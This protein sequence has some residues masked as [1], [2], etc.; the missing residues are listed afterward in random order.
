MFDVLGRVV[1]GG[2]HS[3]EGLALL[4]LHP[5]ADRADGDGGANMTTRDRLLD[6]ADRLRRLPPPDRRDPERFHLERS[7]LAAELRALAAET[8]PGRAA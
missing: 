4:V 8:E 3:A 2:G 6:L 7:D 5:G 1:V